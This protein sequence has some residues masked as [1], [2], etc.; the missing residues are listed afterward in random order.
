M[1]KH[2]LEPT[3]PA[4]T[5]LSVKKEPIMKPTI[6]GKQGKIDQLGADLILGPGKAL[7]RQACLRELTSIPGQVCSY[8]RR[9][10]NVQD[11]TCCHYYAN[12]GTESHR[13]NTDASLRWQTLPSPSSWQ[14][15]ASHYRLPRYE[16]AVS[17]A[18]R[19]SLSGLD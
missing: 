11:R 9:M 10:K 15:Q 7:R 1:H 14:W 17:G 16:Q 4:R 8:T 13:S 19:V 12:V 6:I 3:D 2:L 18:P 5:D